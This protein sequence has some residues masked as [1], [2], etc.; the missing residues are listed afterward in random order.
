MLKKVLLYTLSF[1]LISIFSYTLYAV[2]DNSDD[3]SKTLSSTLEGVITK[4]TTVWRMDFDYGDNKIIRGEFNRVAPVK[5][6][7][8]RYK[9]EFEIGDKLYK[10]SI[11][12]HIPLFQGNYYTVEID[13]EDILLTGEIKR[14]HKKVYKK[15][16]FNLRYDR[17]RFRGDI[18]YERKN[19]GKNINI[20][21]GDKRI[22]GRVFTETRGINSTKKVNLVIDGKKILGSIERGVG[23]EQYKLQASGELTDE[24]LF[25]FFFF[26]I[27]FEIDDYNEEIKDQ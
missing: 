14:S 2:E 8:N 25:W 16:E 15:D 23:F 6:P 3:S 9:I 13:C 20:T 12:Y 22:T 19:D 5:I 24:D 17:T 10:G 4:K 21:F 7:K 27:Y 1:C 18:L 11:F 26:M